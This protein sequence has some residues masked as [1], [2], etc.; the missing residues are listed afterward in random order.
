MHAEIV[1]RHVVYQDNTS[2]SLGLITTIL[3]LFA[4]VVALVISSTK[5]VYV[6]G[7]IMGLSFIVSALFYIRSMTSVWCFFAAVMSFCVFYI[8]RD[9]HKKFHFHRHQVR[10]E[11]VAS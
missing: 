1:G 8:V 11:I 9:E 7:I 10:K 6:L 3:Y 4:T 5:R 2:N